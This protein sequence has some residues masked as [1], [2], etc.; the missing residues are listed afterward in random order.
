M[1]LAIFYNRKPSHVLMEPPQKSPILSLSVNT[2]FA[3][4]VVVFEVIYQHLLEINYY[5][6]GSVFNSICMRYLWVWNHVSLRLITIQDVF[7][8]D[9][10][11]ATATRELPTWSLLLL[12][13]HCRIRAVSGGADS[14]VPCLPPSTPPAPHCRGTPLHLSL[15]KSWANSCHVC[16][17][18]TFQLFIFSI[19]DFLVLVSVLFLIFRA[20]DACVVSKQNFINF[21]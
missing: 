18:H 15:F 2:K 5:S 4:T 10:T 20:C 19:F 7:E 14:V 3:W 8:I 17:R 16:H 9:Q 1:T 13:A 11:I 12:L 21:P 6:F